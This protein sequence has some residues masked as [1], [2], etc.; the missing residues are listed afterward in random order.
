MTEF[1]RIALFRWEM[2]MQR[3][4]PRMCPLDNGSGKCGEPRFISAGP[5]EGQSS[6]WR[7]GGGRWPEY[8]SFSH[9][10]LQATRA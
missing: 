3:T 10:S 5:D 7:S 6:M 9:N 1:A 4:G 2:T 8:L